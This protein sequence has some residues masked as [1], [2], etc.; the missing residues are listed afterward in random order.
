[1]QATKRLEAKQ[2]RDSLKT[3]SIIKNLPFKSIGPTVISGRVVD[4]EGDP[5]NLQ[6]FYVAYAS[7]GLWE[8]KTNGI[9]FLFLRS[10]S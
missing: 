4:I 2:I 1:M 3:Y 8:S 10:K 5:N 6:H 9:E 7:G